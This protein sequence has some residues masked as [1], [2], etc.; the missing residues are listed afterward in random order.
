MMTFQSSS[1]SKATWPAFKGWA[2]ATRAVLGARRWAACLEGSL[3]T[4]THPNRYHLHAYL[5]WTD[6]IGL[7]RKNSDDLV[8]QGV[9]PRIDVCTSRH[10]ATQRD[11]IAA[12]RGLW[13]VAVKKLGT[14]EA[15]SNAHPWRDYRPRGG[16]ASLVVG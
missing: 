4:E 13:Y 9:R 2:K 16:V 6:G 1:F 7:D 12:W 10:A 11:R 3:A 5:F 8:F 14:E 15:A